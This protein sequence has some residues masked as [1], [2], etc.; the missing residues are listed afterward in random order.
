ME[1]WIEP[2][3]PEEFIKQ[4]E[5]MADEWEKGIEVLENGLKAGRNKN[6]Q[7][8]INIAK[9]IYFSFRSTANIVKFYA[10]LRDYK[11]EKEERS[12]ERI[13]DILRKELE[14]AEAD[15]EIWKR[16]PDFGYHPEAAENFTREPD[17]PYK[18]KLLRKQIELLS[19]D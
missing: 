1:T 15:W 8:E 9:H 2:F 12:K 4:M 16:N 17:F 3:S 7:R 13:I 11:E 5:T 19:R 14:I 10:N 18:I 6:F